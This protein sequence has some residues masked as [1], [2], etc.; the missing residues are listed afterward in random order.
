MN[1]SFSSSLSI[2]KDFPVIGIVYQAVEGTHSPPQ[3]PESLGQFRVMQLRVLV[4]QLAAGS[5]CPDHERV[6]RSFDV[7]LPFGA[8]LV[9]DRQHRPVVA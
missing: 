3:L 8:G 1:G 6:H 7:L 9:R 2:L 5:L 4:G